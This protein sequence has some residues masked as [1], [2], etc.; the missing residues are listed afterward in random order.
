MLEGWYIVHT[1]MPRGIKIELLKEFHSDF[2][3]NRVT[4]KRD[5]TRIDWDEMEEESIDLASDLDLSKK[6]G[7]PERVKRNPRTSFVNLNLKPNRRPGRRQ[8]L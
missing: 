3:T 5:R 7:K 1:A 6:R 2:T 8:F 4:K